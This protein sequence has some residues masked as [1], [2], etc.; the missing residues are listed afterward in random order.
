MKTLNQDK[1]QSTAVSEVVEAVRR[2]APSPFD[3][4]DLVRTSLTTFA[5]LE[6]AET[7]RRVAIEE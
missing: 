6:S 4:D 1:G 2:G 7:G 3:L 5:M